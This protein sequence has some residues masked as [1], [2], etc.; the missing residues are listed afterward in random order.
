MRELLGQLAS[1]PSESTGF[2]VAEWGCI[3]GIVHIVHTDCNTD[4]AAAG[5]PSAAV[6][7]TVRIGPVA[8]AADRVVDWGSPEEAIAVS[9]GAAFETV[10]VAAEAAAVV[11]EV[12]AAAA[13][14]GVVLTEDRWGLVVQAWVVYQLVRENPQVV[15]RVEKTGCQLAGVFVVA[16]A[17]EVAAVDEAAAEEVVVAAEAAA[18]VGEVA[19]VVVVHALACLPRVPWAAAVVPVGRHPTTQAHVDVD[20]QR[21]VSP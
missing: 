10:G 20:R 5:D 4:P 9:A 17:G 13:V 12:F 3:L 11:A 6:A 16:V 7:R 1:F 21:L 8:V 19:V 15:P 2:S 18:A 14:A